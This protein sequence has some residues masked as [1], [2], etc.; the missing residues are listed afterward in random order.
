MNQK[1]IALAWLNAGWEVFPCF[2]TDTWAAEKLHTRKSP[3]TRRGFYDATNKKDVVEAYWDAHSGR[4]VGIRIPASV[5]VLDIDLKTD[6]PKDGFEALAEAG[7]DYPSTFSVKTPSGGMHFYYKKD[8]AR[9]VKPTADLKL[10]DGR[11]LEGVD[12]RTLGSYTIAYTTEAPLI[13]EL[14]EAPAWL[15]AETN[16]VGLNPFSGTLNDWFLALPP[17]EPDPRVSRAINRFPDGDFGHSDMLR[18]QTELVNLGAERHV[19]VQQA[20]E[21]LEA[22]WLHGQYNT[23]HNQTSWNSALEGAVRQYGGAKDSQVLI[24]VQVGTPVAS[25]IKPLADAH[26][27]AAMEWV[28]CHLNDTYCWTKFTGWLRYEEGIWKSRSDENLREAIRKI[29]HQF[30]ED[31]RRDPDLHQA[32]STLRGFLSKSRLSALEALL[33]GFLEVEDD[34]LDGHVD[35]LNAKNGVIDL[36]TGELLPHDPSYY[37][38]KQTIC[39]YKPNAKHPDWT[40][41]LAAIPDYALEYI[42]TFFGQSLTGYLLTEDI[43]L[44]LGGGGR[45]GKSTICDL[46]LK[47]M[48]R[49][50]VLASPALL[51]AKDSDHTT[52]LTDLVGKR[53]ALLEEFPQG[54]SL[55]VS[56]LK[57][58]VGTAEI[59]GRRMRQDNQTWDATHTLAITTNHEIYIAS[60][61]DGT[62][63]RLV[64]INFPYRYVSNPSLPNDRPV[65]QGL[66]DRLLAGKEGQHEAVLAWL[67][68]GAIKWFASDRKLPKLP[69]EVQAD[70]DEWRSSQ[71][72]LGSFLKDSVELEPSSW[73]AQADLHQMFKSDYGE[74]NL[75]AEKAF[76]AALKSHEFI[77]SHGIKV[78]TRQRTGSKAI[79]RPNALENSWVSTS[80][81]ANQTTLIKGL[82]FKH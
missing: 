14:T 34:V 1:T 33:R 63:R 23:V 78:A 17:G 54:N 62:W 71:D 59:S 68:E 67:V 12:R 42:H 38:T 32:I 45:N 37:F 43:A 26:D 64:K 57:R 13:E 24:S 50:A 19:G 44:I 18:M 66:R 3:D 29:I 4:L 10:A 40:K 74:N 60:G 46:T 75:Y 16:Q 56:R 41:A 20:L 55:N 79:S 81:L 72:S 15:N 70:I 73:V 48:G 53:F 76:N 35:L 5:N 65:E 11:I 28:A 36:K 47:V 21:M 49:F 25:A 39:D 6:P 30:W 7:L 31:A 8:P 61:D 22:L 2:E 51:T 27:S 9:L 52:E 80:Q 82:R 58:I 69:K 77:V